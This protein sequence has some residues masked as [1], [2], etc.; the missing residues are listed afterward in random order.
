MVFFFFL[1]WEL[2][3]EYDV[4]VIVVVVLQM[5]YDQSCFYWMKFDWEVLEVDFNKFVFCC[6]CNVGGGQN[7]SGGGY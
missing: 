6:G 1:V 2:S 4:Q 7:K 3:D 5:I